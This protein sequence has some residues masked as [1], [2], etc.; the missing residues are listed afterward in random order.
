MPGT[1]LTCWKLRAMPSRAISGGR[2]PATSRPKK[3]TSPPLD[4]ATP[5]SRLNVV[6]LPAPFGPMRPTISLASRCSA[7][8]FTATRP[9][10]VLRSPVAD[11]TSAPRLQARCAA[12]LGAR[13]PA[14]PAMRAVT[15]EPHCAKQACRKCGHNPSGAVCSTRTS[16]TPNTIALVAAALRAEQP[17]Q[18]VLQL[19]AARPSP[20]QRPAARPRPSRRR[21]P[22]PSAS[23][24]SL[25][26]RPNGVGFTLRCMCA[27]SQPA[28]PASTAA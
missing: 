23:T 3:R 24:R 21:R 9:P 17:R 10:N 14:E 2:R 18:Q 1:N 11:S 6:L 22:R 4:R 27:Y 8:S 20:A 16:S 12:W 13:R 5:V 25:A 19:V 26:L 7:M 15:H 28:R